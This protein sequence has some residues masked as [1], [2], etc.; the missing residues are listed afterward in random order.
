MRERI[1]PL[2]ARLYRRIPLPYRLEKWL[3]RRLTPTFLVGVAGVVRDERGQILLLEHVF[4]R[5]YVWGLPGGWIGRGESPA[6]A[7]R[8]EIRE[9]TGLE[10]E[11]TALLAVESD[12]DPDR[13]QI[14]YL[15]SPL[16]QVTHLNREILSAHWRSP[17]DLPGPLPP[18]HC[19]LIERVTGDEERRTNDE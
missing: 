4:H 18:F 10:V 11:I 12:R 5:Y 15:C 16:G 8:R 17:A 6:D 9:E 13:L 2:I 7:L 1:K 19:A 14:G 3:I